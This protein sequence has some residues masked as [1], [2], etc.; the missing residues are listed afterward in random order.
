MPVPGVCIALDAP[1][2]HQLRRFH[3]V[4][5]RSPFS[6]IQIPMIFPFLLFPLLFEPP[7]FHPPMPDIRWCSVISFGRSK[8][9]SIGFLR[10]PVPSH[11]A[12]PP[13][14]RSAEPPADPRRSHSRGRA[15]KAAACQPYAV[16]ASAELSVDRADKADGHRQLFVPH[17]SRR[18]VSFFSRSGV[19]APYHCSSSV[20][21][22]S[23]DGPTYDF[24]APTGITSMNRT[25]TF[26]ALQIQAVPAHAV[27]FDAPH[28]A[29][30]KDP[31][32]W[33]RRC[34]ALPAPAHRVR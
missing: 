14:F 32:L 29:S 21:S 4:L 11:P 26:P 18:T 16:A 6:L 15:L 20:F 25:G 34:P 31:P 23:F 24:P 28:S 27:L 9:C 8:Q 19:H 3:L 2:F 22:A 12:D 13:P 1:V 30:L 5:C 33:P 10:L 17:I 7:S